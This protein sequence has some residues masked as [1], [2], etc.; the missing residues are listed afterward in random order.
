VRRAVDAGVKVIDHGQLLDEATVKLLWGTD[1]LFNPTQ[2]RNQ[3]KD[4]LRLK[5]WFTPAQALKL[6]THD[7]AQVFA[8]SGPRNPYPGKLGVVE[9]G[10]YADVILVDGDPLA[11][12]DIVADPA[13]NFVVIMEDGKVYKNTLARWKAQLESAGYSVATLLAK[14]E[15]IT[16]A[17]RAAAEA[18]VARLDGTD[19]KRPLR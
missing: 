10:A 14:R 5:R 1:F 2:N 4:I 8:L 16:A 18:G 12:L 7:N 13:K 6:V 15:A 3:N 17:R 9:E 11:N 19:P